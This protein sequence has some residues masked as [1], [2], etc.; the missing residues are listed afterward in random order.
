MRPSDIADG[1]TPGRTLTMYLELLASM[2]PSDITDGIIDERKPYPTRNAPRFNEAVG[3]HRRN[4]L[5]SLP[6]AS[7]PVIVLQ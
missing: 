3:Y 6:S 4:R 5:V 1:I 2:R 7:L